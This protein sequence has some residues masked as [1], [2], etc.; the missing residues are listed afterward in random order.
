M[1]PYRGVTLLAK[2]QLIQF[3]LHFYHLLHDLSRASEAV[4][5]VLLGFWIFS[6]FRESL[7]PLRV[8]RIFAQPAAPGTV[9]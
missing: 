8:Q 6:A 2:Q 1:V 9:R 5:L 4:L 7:L 3:F